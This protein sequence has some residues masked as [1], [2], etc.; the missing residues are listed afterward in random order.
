MTG[1]QTSVQ[2]NP[3]PA[4][5]GAWASANPQFSMLAGEGELTSGSLAAGAVSG[6]A[7]GVMVGRFAWARNDNGQVSNQHPGVPA[8]LGFVQRDQVVLITPWLAQASEVVP[9]GLDVTLYDWC[10]VWGRFAA[11]CSRQQKVFASYADGS[12]IAGT[13]GTPPDGAAFTASVGATFTATG[14]G[15]SLAV[16]SVTGLISIGDEIS[17]TGVT[18]GTT[19]TAQV[20]GTPGGAGTYTTSAATT[21]AADTVTSFGN[22]LNV[23]AVASGTIVNGQPV[24]GTNL[25]TG[26]YITD[27]ISGTTGGVGLYH[28]SAP[29]TQYVAAASDTTDGGQETNLYTATVADS[30]E[31]AQISPR[32]S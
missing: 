8:R 7:T 1:F 5:E 15:T 6:G 19:I 10:D 9:T 2:A 24:H 22:V 21:S 29:T 3:V 18:A 12:L 28:L 31:L 13:A 27:Q 11:G 17:G 30:G 26:A 20:S 16:T 25:P 32:S 14:T 23:S 4:L